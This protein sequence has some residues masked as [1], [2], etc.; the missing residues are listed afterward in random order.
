MSGAIKRHPKK[1]EVQKKTKIKKQGDTV[2]KIE[3]G[4]DVT[5]WEENPG[6]KSDLKKEVKCVGSWM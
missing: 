2:G 5:T 6:K 4:R 1:K 3:G